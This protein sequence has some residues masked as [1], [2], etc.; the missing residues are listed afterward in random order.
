MNAKCHSEILFS[1]I[2]VQLHPRDPLAITK[3]D[4]LAGTILLA[5]AGTLPFQQ[6]EIGS[7]IPAGH[8]FAL[9]GISEGNE[10][11]RYG[12]RIGIATQDISPGDWIHS[13]N[14]NVGN[15]DRDFKI[16]VVET[17]TRQESLGDN[18]F[19]MGYPRPG[20][21]YGTRNYIAVISTV[22]CSAQTAQAIAQAFTPER[23]VGFPN[24]DGVVAITHTAGCC[25]PIEGIAYKYLQRT[26]INL[27]RHPNVGG[28]VF[29]SLG[30]EGNQMADLV[31]S[32]KNEAEVPGPSIVGPYLVIQKEGGIAKTIQSGIQ[33]VN[34]MLPQVNAMTRVVVPLSALTVALQCGGSDGWS[35]VT[36]N[37]LVGKVSDIIVRHGGTVVLS[38]TP[39]IYGAEHLLTSRSIS[40]EVGQKL[41]DWIR[42]WQAQADLLGFSLDNNPTPGNKEGGLTTIYEKSLGAIVKG[43]TTPLM[44]VYGY[45]E[46]VT[47]KGL[48]LM[49]TPGNDPVSITGQV[50]GGCNLILFTTGR[51]SVLGGKLAPCIKVASNTEMYNR[52]ID[53]MDYNAGSVLDGTPMDT[54]AEILLG[55][56]I[57]SASGSL[58]KS[59]ANGFREFEF[60]PWQPGAIL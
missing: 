7:K 45:A 24:I 49:D 9:K 15:L 23:L 32:Q 36:S 11:L 27:T 33:A 10:I 43:G 5:D 21:Q 30:C 17:E 31:D 47:S 42:W 39:E 58:T 46:Q 20:G 16:K 22:S 48:V 14:M 52:M 54:V 28:V 55:K 40:E 12:Y 44:N 57:Q 53:D 56:V 51:G 3:R 50:A 35:G 41:I 26:L 29:I 8:K 2:A 59:E 1:Q 60:I 13:H 37:P 38:E 34:A 18:R 6:I 19:F 25:V 4:I